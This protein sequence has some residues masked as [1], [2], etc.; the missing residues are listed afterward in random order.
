VNLHIMPKKFPKKPRTVG[1]R[2]PLWD[3]LNSIA[4][5]EDRSVSDVVEEAAA[6]YV[7]SYRLADS[8]EVSREDVAMI[9]KQLITEASERLP[10]GRQNSGERPS[11][12]VGQLERELKRRGA[13]T[14]GRQEHA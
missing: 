2:D 13:K 4:K 5:R 8:A 10:A 6:E 7:A 12:V 14:R 11:R 9:V 1:F 3:D